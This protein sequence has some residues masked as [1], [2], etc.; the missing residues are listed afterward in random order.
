VK[1]VDFVLDAASPVFA[2]ARTVLRRTV[3][4]FFQPS[5]KL[6]DSPLQVSNEG[7]PASEVHPLQDSTNKTETDASVKDGSNKVGRQATEREPR[8]PRER[9]P[10]ADGIPSK[11][12][13]MVANLP[14]DLSEEKVRLI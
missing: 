12:K 14:Y 2:L 4:V 9:G 11:T 5:D 7:L 8:Q 10:P 13:I 6:V 1:M 3:Y